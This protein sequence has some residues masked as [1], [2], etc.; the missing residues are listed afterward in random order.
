MQAPRETASPSKLCATL[1]WSRRLRME[2]SNLCFNYSRIRYAM[3]AAAAAFA[4][5]WFSWPAHSAK[6]EINIAKMAVGMASANLTSSGRA[7]VSRA[8]GPSTAAKWR[9]MAAPSKNSDRVRPTTASPS[10]LLAASGVRRRG[11]HSLQSGSREY[12]SLRR[13]RRSA[14]KSL[15]LLRCSGQRA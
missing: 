2:G 4:V 14:H 6:T 9:R 5:A 1:V 10:D 15:R 7:R 11:D 3:T 12:R 13:D 8:N